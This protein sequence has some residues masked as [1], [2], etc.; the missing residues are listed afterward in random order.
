MSACR[1]HCVHGFLGTDEIPRLESNDLGEPVPLT[2]GRIWTH[3]E[4]CRVTRE[5]TAV[6][7]CPC[8][9]GDRDPEREAAR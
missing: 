6:R 9:G 5:R 3:L 4:F 1:R 2:E 7:L 8:Q